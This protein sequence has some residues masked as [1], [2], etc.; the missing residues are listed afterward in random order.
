VAERRCALHRARRYDPRDLPDL[1]AHY[2]V[3]LVL[4]PVGGPET[5]SYTLSEAWAAGAP[6]ARAADR[7]AARARRDRPS[8]GG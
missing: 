8:A 6:G 4:F 2:R 1:L 7:R 3:S 5:F